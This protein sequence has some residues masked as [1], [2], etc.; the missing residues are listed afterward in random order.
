MTQ[1]DVVARGGGHIERHVYIMGSDAGGRDLLALIARG[2]LPSLRLVLLAVLIRMVI[3]TALGAA[4]GLG[5]FPARLLSLAMGR[6]VL[7]FPYLVLAIIVIQALLRYEDRLVA[8]TI[9]IAVIGWRDVAQ[10]TADRIEAVLSQPYA[11][12]ARA[13]GTGSFGI[14]WRH[15]VPHLRPVLLT[16][17]ALQASAVLVILGELGYLGYYLGQ[18]TSFNAIVLPSPELGQLLSVARDYILR[19]QWIPVLVPAA[20]LA[21]A[22]L[23]FELLAIGLRH[24]W[25]DTWE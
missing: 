13:L 7:G 6:W 2:S 22:A 3:G 14:F 17:L 9:A 21:L 25:V 10:L 11:T 16:E 8:F 1:L 12:A 19:E 23:A 5:S 4:T 18:P 15:V 24:R 20:M